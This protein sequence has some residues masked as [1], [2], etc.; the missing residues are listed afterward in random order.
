MVEMNGDA[1]SF[2]QFR[3]EESRDWKALAGESGEIDDAAWNPFESLMAELAE[4]DT[5]NRYL[6]SM[7]WDFWRPDLV[8]IHC[9]RV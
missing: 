2:C 7:G 1:I 3:C 9:H 8:S 6:G 4:E 5:R